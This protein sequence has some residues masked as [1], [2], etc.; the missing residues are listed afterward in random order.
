MSERNNGQIRNVAN[1]LLQINNASELGFNLAAVNVKNR[2]LK[3]ILKSFAQERAEYAREL[4]QLVQEAGGDPAEGSGWLATIHRGWINIKAAM[5]IGQGPT[6]SVVLAEVTRGERA[7]HQAYQQALEQSLPVA[8]QTMLQQQY[9]GLRATEERIRQLRGREGQRTV[10]RLFDSEEDAQSAAGALAD[11]GYPISSIEQLQMEELVVAYDAQ[12]E[13]DTTFESALAGAL[14]GAVLGIILGLVAS[15]SAWMA[16]G[17]PL[18]G[19]SLI[20]TAGAILLGALLAGLILGGLLGVIIGTGLS[21]DDAYRY[22]DSL[23]RGALLLLVKTT[24]ED[25]NRA[26]EIMQAVN[27]RRWLGSSRA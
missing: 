6:E 10:V 11:A 17:E 21:Q 2:G 20:Q 7:A 12:G 5:T 13:G 25:A 16:P 26:S 14:V 23:T 8:V 9:Q 19:A 3:L 24:E 4:R 18:L 27:T 15:V 1:R 22:S